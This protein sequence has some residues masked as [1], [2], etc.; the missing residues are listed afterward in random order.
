MRTPSLVHE[1]QASKLGSPCRWISLG[2]HRGIRWSRCQLT[3]SSKPTASQNKACRDSPLDS[4]LS[5][6]QAAQRDSHFQMRVEHAANQIINAVDFLS[7]KSRCPGVLSSSKLPVGGAR[8]VQYPIPRLDAR[9]MRPVLPHASFRPG[10]RRRGKRTVP[11]SWGVA[12][13]LA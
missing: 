11:W 6:A 1:N 8:T 12:I 13:K 9:P 5:T 4:H 3:E 10:V 7:S 2:R